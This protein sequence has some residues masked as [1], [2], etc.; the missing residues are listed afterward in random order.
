MQVISSV[1]GH[2]ME[3]ENEKMRAIKEYSSYIDFKQSP[4]CQ[5]V[6]LVYVEL[7]KYELQ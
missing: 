6:K 2:R 5:S 3:C 4:K 7:Q 1:I